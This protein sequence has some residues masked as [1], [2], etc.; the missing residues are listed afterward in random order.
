M[1]IVL[2]GIDGCGKSTVA[3][4]MAAVLNVKWIEFPDRTTVTGRVID[5][6]LQHRLAVGGSEVLQALFA[7]NRYEKL[8]ELARA[9][10]SS[11][12]VCSRYTP[13]G[14]VYGEVSGLERRWLEQI[15]AGLPEPDLSL[16]LDVPP[17]VG[18]SRKGGKALEL[19]EK[20]A[21]Q[22]RVRQLYLDLWERRRKAGNGRYIVV[23][24]T[25]PQAEVLETCL[26]WYE[27]R[28]RNGMRG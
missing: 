8:P 21:T 11:N 5:D 19:Y 25:Q 18:L 13:S 15:H 9:L 2:E 3:Q 24:A 23:D 6:V 26:H 22:E 17:D 7:V 20:L 1:L 10:C 12:L 14:L 27:A 28:R 4:Q 16:L